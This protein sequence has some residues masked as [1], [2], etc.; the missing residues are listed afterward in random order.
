MR[1]T[2]AEEDLV[3]AADAV[4]ATVKDDPTRR[5]LGSPRIE[6]DIVLFCEGRARVRS[7]PGDVCQK[8]AKSAAPHM[9]CEGA[10]VKAEALEARRWLD[11]V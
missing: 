4:R 1:K 9:A 10:H 6:G 8:R 5:P 11:R 3:G 2:A 7:G